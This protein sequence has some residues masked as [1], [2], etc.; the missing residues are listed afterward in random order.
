MGR[1]SD[2]PL[3]RGRL[4]WLRARPW[5]VGVIA[6]ASVVLASACVA[7]AVPSILSTLLPESDQA[8]VSAPASVPAE[9]NDDP[10]PE[11]SDLFTFDAKPPSPA[12][13]ETQSAPPSS[14]QPNTPEAPPVAQRDVP[15]PVCPSGEVSI[16][17]A[18]MHLDGTA[19]TAGV[20]RND[21]DTPV[22]IIGAPGAW[23]VDTAGENIIP[24]GG[25]FQGNTDELLPGDFA[26]FQVTSAPVT[27]EELSAIIE[28]K[29]QGD[30]AYLS[31]RWYTT[32][33]CSNKAPIVVHIMP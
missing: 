3:P 4:P 13:V 19:W 27:P 9:S 24:V 30:G 23:G 25:Y 29:Y 31:A 21:S 18:E 2:D 17:Y 32:P 15:A 16:I 11:P 20:I 8:P 7:L 33:D 14:P 22:Q 6:G 1:N 12:P 5:L 10:A 28:W 26:E